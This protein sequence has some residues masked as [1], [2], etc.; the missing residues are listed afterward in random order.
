VRRGNLILA[1]LGLA[2]AGAT[3]AC[4]R[5]GDAALDARI[6]AT[7]ESCDSMDDGDRFCEATFAH[8][9]GCAAICK[10]G[11]CES[12]CATCFAPD[13]QGDGT[14]TTG[15]GECRNQTGVYDFPCSTEGCCFQC[16]FDSECAADFGK[17]AICERHCGSCC[18]PTD[19]FV[20]GGVPCGCI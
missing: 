16:A 3:G 8:A 2:A 13:P 15:A 6:D 20:D 4:A 7:A 14:C 10:N 1:L 5:D 19:G 18:R 9:P 12:H 11:H 17:G